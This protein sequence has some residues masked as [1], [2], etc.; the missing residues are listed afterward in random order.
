MSYTNKTAEQIIQ[1]IQQVFI[2]VFKNPSLSESSVI[3]QLVEQ[4]SLIGIDVEDTRALLRGYV[5]DPAFA[6]GKYLDSL[7]ALHQITRL[8]PKP[9]QVGCL[10]TGAV[11]TVIPAG[12]IVLNTAGNR[13]VIDTGVTIPPAGV[14]A[15]LFTSEDNGFIPCNANTVNRILQK[16]TGWDSVNNPND[17][18]LGSVGE[19]DTALRK[20]RQISLSLNAS[21]TLKSIISAL[22]NNQ[23]IRD[24][25]IVENNNNTDLIVDSITILPKSI[26][27]CVDVDTQYYPQV[28]QILYEKK[29]GGCGMVGGIT[30]TYIDP[31]YP[32]ETFTAKFDVANIIQT[33]ISITVVNDNFTAETIPSI[34]QAIYNN[35]YG[36]DGTVPV[37]MGEPFYAGRFYAPVVKLGIY[38]ITALTIGIAPNPTGTSITT[39]INEVARLN[40]NNIVVTVI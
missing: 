17:G 28:A 10:I 26:Y 13:F 1:E 15:V 20:R 25:N 30:Q 22:E 31:L 19:T 11:G 39:A 27:L 16:I 7:C 40:L 34:K 4:L 18:T 37:Q 3:G 35:F 36:L 23:N 8:P 38:Q 5:Y 29:S 21:G 32:W 24:Y 14:I 9:S 6:S 12:S 2:N 33:Y